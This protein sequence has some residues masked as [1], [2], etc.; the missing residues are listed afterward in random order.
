MPVIVVGVAT[1]SGV[2]Q[3]GRDHDPIETVASST[4]PNSSL[5]LNPP[6]SCSHTITSSKSPSIASVYVVLTLSHV[7]AN[8]CHGPLPIC[9]LKYV[10]VPGTTSSTD[11]GSVPHAAIT[12]ARSN[13]FTWLRYSITTLLIGRTPSPAG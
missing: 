9:P 2:T 3:V 7:P 12:A 1:S 13:A 4:V 10:G 5:A 11:V 6:S 8:V